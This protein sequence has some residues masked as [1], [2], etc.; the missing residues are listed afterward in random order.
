MPFVKGQSGNPKGRGTGNDLVNPKSL[1]G[2]EIR[3]KEFKQILRRLKPLNN[4]AMTKLNDLIDSE[5]TTE[6]TRMKAIVFVMKT[7]QDMMNDLYEPVNGGSS[8]GDGRD[9]KS[10][11]TPLISFKVLEGGK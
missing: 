8:D 2:E 6:A 4:K 11:S 10:D 7:Y 1:T 5:G 3:E 9:D